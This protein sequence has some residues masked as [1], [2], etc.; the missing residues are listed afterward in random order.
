[1]P[2]ALPWHMAEL[3]LTTK[4]SAAEIH[5]QLYLYEIVFIHM[6][7]KMETN[8]CTYHHFVL[9]R[10]PTSTTQIVV[11]CWHCVGLHA[12]G[13]QH[14]VVVVLAIEYQLISWAPVKETS[15]TFK[16]C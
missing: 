1:M 2:V 3:G 9:S 13:A 6:L 12:G 5:K 8:L 11:Y 14:R 4:R 16:I 7:Q 15:T 10:L